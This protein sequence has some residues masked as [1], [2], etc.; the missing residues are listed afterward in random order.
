MSKPKKPLTGNR[1]R[2]LPKVKPLD[3]D[4][5]LAPFRVPAPNP[6]D[7]RHVPGQ[8]AMDFSR[9]ECDALTEEESA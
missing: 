4:K 2:A 9:D 1:L 3:R 5:P 7:F 6:S 8:A